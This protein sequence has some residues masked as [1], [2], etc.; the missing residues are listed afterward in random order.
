LI[1]ENGVDIGAVLNDRR[2]HHL[3]ITTTVIAGDRGVGG[4]GSPIA[5]LLLLVSILP[6]GKET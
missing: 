2:I 1:G 5:S 3:D 6:D 4:G